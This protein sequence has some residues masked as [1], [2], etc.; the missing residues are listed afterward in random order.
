MPYFFFLPAILSLGLSMAWISG[1]AN[2]RRD[3]VIASHGEMTSVLAGTTPFFLEIY[4][5]RDMGT[6][7]DGVL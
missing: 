2:S 3:F 6:I 7:L 4:S 1:S 5:A